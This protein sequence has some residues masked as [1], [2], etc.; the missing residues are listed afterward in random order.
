MPHNRFLESVPKYKYL[1]MKELEKN[2]QTSEP[3][4]VCG[5]FNISL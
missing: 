4:V 2:S 3:N 1:T 5:N